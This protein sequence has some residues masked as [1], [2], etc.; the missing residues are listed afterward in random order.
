MPIEQPPLEGPRIE[1]GALTETELRGPGAV[2]LLYSEC[3]ELR[4]KHSATLAEIQAER[5]RNE[6]LTFRVHTSE[7]DC[8]VLRERLHST[9]YRDTIARL[10]EAVIAIVVGYAIDLE[11]SSDWK[12]FAVAASICC[13]LFFAIFLTQRGSHPGKGE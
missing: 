6:S 2:K 8:A 9:G 11:R 4:A 10:I 13:I 1:L 3:I 5:L 12:N 7:T